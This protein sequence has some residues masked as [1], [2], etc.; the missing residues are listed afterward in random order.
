MHYYPAYKFEDVLEMNTVIYNSMV[1]LMNINEARDG[2][3]ELEFAVYPKLKQ[4]GRKELHRNYYRIA[5]PH[6]F[7][8]KD[9]V[10]LSDISKV[11][12]G[13]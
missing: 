13:R 9:V 12:N 4:D 5:H 8:H 6:N 2:L 11:L 3:R 1:K 7:E 10:S